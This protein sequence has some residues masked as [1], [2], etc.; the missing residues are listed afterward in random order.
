M[1][2]RWPVSTIR[3]KGS[4]GAVQLTPASAALAAFDISQRMIPDERPALHMMFRLPGYFTMLA[5]DHRIP[6][7]SPGL[8]AWGL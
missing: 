6:V 8:E 2:N 7:R 4:V 5:T 3:P 1:V